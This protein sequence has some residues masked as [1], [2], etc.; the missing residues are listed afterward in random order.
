MTIAAC[1]AY[2]CDMECA[3]DALPYTMEGQWRTVNVC[4]DSPSEAGAR[5]QVELVDTWMCVSNNYTSE[6]YSTLATLSCAECAFEGWCNPP[7]GLL[8]ADED[9]GKPYWANWS[10]TGV[11][12]SAPRNPNP[13][14]PCEP[15]PLVVQ[16]KSNRPN[17]AVDNA[18]TEWRD[19]HN[20]ICGSIECTLLGPAYAACATYTCSGIDS[21]GA[22]LPEEL[23][24][25]CENEAGYPPREAAAD[26]YCSHH[27]GCLREN[28]TCNE[29]Y[30]T[31]GLI[32]TECGYTCI[33]TNRYT[34]QPCPEVLISA[35]C[36]GGY[37]PNEEA[38]RAWAYG[39]EV[40]V[41]VVCGEAAAPPAKSVW[42]CVGERSEIIHPNDPGP[43]VPDPITVE[44]NA[45]DEWNARAMAA[46]KWRYETN[47]PQTCKDIECVESEPTLP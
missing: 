34:G 17:Y 4:A 3:V 21:S 36:G 16:A 45:G 31:G 19:K 25:A 18:Y 24:E 35:S 15:N 33:G 30:T 12:G 23:V 9:Q 11:Q 42:E 26:A 14:S 40:C 13:G 41:N 1:V 47:P 28:V 44:A 27:P 29:A 6:P 10:C 46:H 39:D 20:Q 37:A 5:A 8:P 38:V 43:C 2:T 7:G 32:G 22:G